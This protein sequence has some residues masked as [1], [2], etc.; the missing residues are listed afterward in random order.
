MAPPQ[1][2]GGPPPPTRPSRPTLP[3]R[4][5]DP[6]ALEPRPTLTSMRVLPAGGALPPPTDARAEASPQGTAETADTWRH[7]ALTGAWHTVGSALDADIRMEDAAGRH[8]RIRRVAGNRLEV[9]DLGRGV[10]VNGKRV[11][12]AV[13][14]LDARIEL[15]GA[16]LPPSRIP[17]DVLLESELPRLAQSI[18]IGRDGSVCQLAVNDARVSTR[19]ARLTADEEGWVLEDLQSTN[20]TMVNGQKVRRMRI[21]W[22][23]AFHV[24]EVRLTPLQVVREVS[25]QAAPFQGTVM[26]AV[27]ELAPPPQDA[28]A[29]A[30][31]KPRM[32]VGRS[33]EADIVVDSPHVSLRHVLVEQKPDGFL[34]TDLRSTNG[35]FVNGERI[36]APTLVRPR[37]VFHL[38]G[39]PF[40]LDGSG[41]AEAPERACV[42]GLRVELQEASMTAGGATVVDRVT[43][44]VE[45]GEMVAIM[46]PSGAGK[47]S[48]LTLLSG[49][50]VPSSGAVLLDGLDAHAHD[51]IFRHAVALVPQED[52]MHRMLTPSEVLFFTG[53]LNFPADTTAAE[54]R[55]RAVQVLKRLDLEH[56][57]HARVGDE[58]VRGLSGGERKRVNVAMELMHE[59]SLLLLD[60]PT[61]GLDGRSALQLVRQCRGL[62][63]AGRTVMMTIHQPREEALALFD[64]VLLL[65]QGGRPAYFGP[66]A[67]IRHYFETHVENAEAGAANAADFALE[68]LDPQDSARRRPPEFWADTFRASAQFSEVA[69]RQRQGALEGSSALAAPAPQRARAWRQFVTLA[70]RYALVKW[71][72]RAALGL[73]LL[74]APLIAAVTVLLFHRGR[75]VPIRG[76]DDVTPALFVAAASAVWLGT[77]N[78]A[79]EVVGDRAIF[80]RESRRVVRAG[81]YL[82]AV[83]AVQ[84]LL[85]LVQLPLL[86]GLEQMFVKFTAPF[87]LLGGV[88]MLLGA[89]ALMMGLLVSALVRTQMAAAVV[90]PL[91]ILPQILLSGQLAPVGGRSA[92]TTQQVLAAPMLLRWGYSALVNVE[93]AEL[94]E[95]RAETPWGLRAAKGREWVLPRL[96]FEHDPPWLPRTLVLVM[97]LASG[98]AAW[99]VLARR[100]RRPVR[101]TAA[102]PPPTAPP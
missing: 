25:H 43:V 31:T 20:G 85:I 8:A 11:E 52:V 17:D 4:P 100:A 58:V 48:L 5:P 93:F 83:T 99:W 63:T 62:A 38:G 34:V 21:G 64:K 35:T 79:R 7:D 68:V 1:K 12:R 65:A 18:V 51:A 59:P 74:Q 95:E 94:A 29:R 50:G 76:D 47:T 46:G 6:A 54:I 26:V 90:V 9:E 37:Q 23:Q 69:A 98:A 91:L 28:L 86:V 80:A 42:H 49:H 84:L 13:V 78:V 22:R 96:G 57:A 61:S 33:P 87:L 89:A 45:P 60:E 53:R 36:T 39:Y 81:P 92:T 15:A 19:H 101:R 70:W 16:V 82:A 10:W 41:R 2:P 3:T 32:V 14:A 67:G 66:P 102:L 55:T 40:K 27:D 97:G 77:S 75:F 73:Q 30:A 24:A 71:R 72:D 44:C 88:V 56:A